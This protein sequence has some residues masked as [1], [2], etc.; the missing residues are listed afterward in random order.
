[1]IDA[2]CDNEGRQGEVGKSRA[3]KPRY[4]GAQLTNHNASSPPSHVQRRQMDGAEP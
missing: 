3:E 4:L 2:S 1:M